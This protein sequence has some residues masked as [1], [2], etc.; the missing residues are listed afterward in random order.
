MLRRCLSD[1]T[2]EDEDFHRTSN[3]ENEK[4]FKKNRLSKP[5]YSYASLIAQAILS[6]AEK[7]MTLNNIYNWIVNHYPYYRNQSNGWQNSI[8]HNLSL[9]KC[10]KKIPRTSN[11]P[12]KGAFWSIDKD[13][14]TDFNNGTL[15]KRKSPNNED[16]FE[17]TLIKDDSS[18][19]KH[20]GLNQDA[21][22]NKNSFRL[23]ECIQSIDSNPTL[24]QFS[25]LGT[26]KQ[27]LFQ[28]DEDS[29]QFP[30]HSSHLALQNQFNFTLPKFN[31]ITSISSL[32][33]NSNIDAESLDNIQATGPSQMLFYDLTCPELVDNYW[34]FE[35]SASQ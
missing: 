22:F 13:Y 12:G 29:F 7:K 26:P 32:I 6:S 31:A 2:I 18:K 24:S 19:I 25:F 3:N 9:N 1:I 14:I 8:R 30:S 34:G 16:C 4:N 5:N 28:V 23:P 21:K 20:T 27:N 10:F 11:E 33:P 15:K 17:R 35:Y